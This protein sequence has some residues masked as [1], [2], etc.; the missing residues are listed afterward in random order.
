[1]YLPCLSFLHCLLWPSQV[2]DT[3]WFPFYTWGNWG[4]PENSRNL[5][6]VPELIRGNAWMWDLYRGPS[7]WCTK[8]KGC[9]KNSTDGGVKFCTVNRRLLMHSKCVQ[10]LCLGQ[11]LVVKN[12][13]WAVIKKKKLPLGEEGVMIRKRHAGK[14]LGS[15]DCFT[16]Q[17]ESDSLYHGLLNYANVYVLPVCV[18]HN[19]PGTLYLWVLNP[20]IT[21]TPDQKYLGGKNN[22][23]NTI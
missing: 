18:F 14:V 19:T 2:Y 4:V 1:M 15:W 5:S 9:S 13:V 3:F 6:R 21:P 8:Q 20:Q 12:R 23:N 17:P 16:T 11:H 10:H 7:T 22:K